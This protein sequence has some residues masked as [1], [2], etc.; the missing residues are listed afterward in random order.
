VNDTEIDPA[1]LPTLVE[2]NGLTRLV[3]NRVRAQVLVTLLYA[4]EPLTP[5]EIASA[6][7]VTDSA[8][9]EALA[10]LSAFDLFETG[11]TGDGGETTRYALAAD[12]ELVAA[13]ERLARLATERRYPEA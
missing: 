12:D 3:A 8:V 4:D 6:A 5:G 1:E 10:P 7:G 13:V 2:R 11:D 9:H